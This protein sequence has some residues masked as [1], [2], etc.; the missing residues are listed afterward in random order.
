MK[1]ILEFSEEKQ[2]LYFNTGDELNS[3]GYKPLAYCRSIEDANLFASFIH[4]QF[5]DR[6]IRLSFDEAEKTI[7]NLE[8]FIFAYNK[9]H[10]FQIDNEFEENNLV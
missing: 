6:D 4:I 9:M 2:M 10:D 1:T 7:R 8:R 5:L 3:D